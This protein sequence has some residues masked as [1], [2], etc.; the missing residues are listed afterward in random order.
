MAQAQIAAVIGQDNPAYHALAKPQGFHVDN[1]GHGLSAAFTSAGVDFHRGP[2]HWGMSLRGYGYGDMRRDVGAVQP[3]AA[4]NRVEDRRG[5]LTEWY[6]NGP[7]GLEQGFTL[8]RAPSNSNGQPLTLAFVMSG[9]LTPSLD[10]GGRSLTLRTDKTGALRYGGLIA[11]D[12]NGRDLR[13]WLEIAGHEL[14][15]RV[16]D[17]GARYPLMIDPYV[18]AP[19]LDTAM[20]CDPTGVC[21]DGAAWNRFGQSVSISA[22]GSTVVVGA[23]F[24]INNNAPGQGAAYVFVKPDDF[25]GGWHSAYP[26]HFKAK[27]LASDIATQMPAAGL[28]SR[29]Q[30]RW[31]N[32]RG[33]GSRKW[34]RRIRW[35]SVCLHQ[36]G[37]R[38]GNVS[39]SDRDR[40]TCAWTSRQLRPLQQRRGVSRY[41]RRRGNDCCWRA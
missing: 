38:L 8:E 2:N 11:L 14:R 19:R 36:T 7:L 13:A 33:R 10:P 4:A 17:A 23:P 27:L 16:D 20:P 25:A 26:N 21:D 24:K 40:Q 3:K 34:R 32:D 12:S 28:F 29:Y 1:P 31:R 18:Q 37:E 35:C 5:A 22:D 39:G 15:V 30:S 6:V 41:Q 9:N